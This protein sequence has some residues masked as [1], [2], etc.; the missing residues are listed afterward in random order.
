MIGVVGAGLMG[1]GIAQ[2]FAVAGHDVRIYDADPDQV[3]SAL[4]DIARFTQRDVERGELSAAD[5]EAALARVVAV[6]SLGEVS[7][8]AELVIEA[9]V[10]NLDV[11]RD[12]LA[13]LEA[14]AEADTILASNTSA[15]SI[16]AI[17]ADCDDPSRV[18]GL[19]FFNPVPRMPLVEVVSGLDTSPAT[20]LRAVALCQGAGKQTVEVNES[21]GFATTRMNAMIGNEA[22]YMLMEGVA[23][24]SDI[25]KAMKLGLNHPM[26]P[27]ELGDLVGW[28]TRLRILEHLHAELG[29]KFKPCPLIVEY[30]A[31]GRLG[32]KVGRGVYRYDDSGRRTEHA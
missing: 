28:D 6:A 14:S 20:I 4:A 5:R 13:Q 29:E 2:V 32:R 9:V 24:A 19:H 10:E 8:G 16:T 26:G 27:L 21:P 23:T 15:L 25:D 11:K 22:M 17:G 7:G 1:R 31:D 12:L 30:V 18:L 3:A